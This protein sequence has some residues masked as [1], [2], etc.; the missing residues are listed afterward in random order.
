MRA[1]FFAFLFVLLALVAG[2][3]GFFASAPMVAEAGGIGGGRPGAAGAAGATGPTGATGAT[4]PNWTTCAAMAS[5]MSGAVTGTCGSAVLSV[6]PAFTGATTADR[7]TAT[8]TSGTA[9]TAT[10]QGTG[11][12]GNFTSG[13]TSA[14]VHT[15]GAVKATP[16]QSSHDGVLASGGLGSCAVYA[17]ANNGTANVCLAPGA[18][19]NSDAMN[20]TGLGTGAG[21]VFTGGASGDGIQ[22][23][24]PSSGYAVK[25]TATNNGYALAAFGDSTSPSNPPLYI[26]PDDAI[27]SGG[28]VIGDFRV[29]TIGVF[30][31]C[32]A[33]GTP[34]TW[35]DVASFRSVTTGVT[36][37]ATGGQASATVVCASGGMTTLGTVASAGDS[38]KFPPTPVV[39]Q[40]CTIKNKGANSANLFPGSGD[41][42]C[43][44]GSACGAAD[45]STAI[46]ANAQLDCYAESV[47]TWNCR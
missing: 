3:L 5:S 23:T 9:I 41:A 43:V 19:T 36:A 39:G 37:F 12:G 17:I 29:S 18:N 34:G 13:G 42:I 4:G 14:T 21:G 35:N 25:A 16:G 40:M 44:S 11:I 7:L 33:N 45:A 31:T 10:G 20:A 22:A 32:T 46:A 24:A 38:V 6:A 1:V 8:S 27:P 2:S 30:Q 15:V 28:N 26:Q 47:S